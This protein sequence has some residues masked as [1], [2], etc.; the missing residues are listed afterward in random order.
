MEREGVSV[1]GG[2]GTNKLPWLKV[3]AE[4]NVDIPSNKIIFFLFI[5]LF[6]IFK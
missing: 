3:H 2:V 6:L 5:F 1:G 4:R